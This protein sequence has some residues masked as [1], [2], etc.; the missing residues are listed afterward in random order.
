MASSPSSISNP[1]EPDTA[2]IKAR[3]PRPRRRPPL[4]SFCSINQKHSQRVRSRKAAC[5]R[6]ERR[7]RLRDRLAGPAAELVAHML[8]HEPLSRNDIDGL[9]DILPHLRQLIAAAAWTGGRH[10]VNDARARQVIRKVA[11]RRLAALK[12]LNGD[13]WRFR[14]GSVLASICSQLLELQF[15]LIDEPLAAPLRAETTST[16]LI[17][18]SFRTRA[19]RMACTSARTRPVISA[20]ARRPPIGQLRNVSSGTVVSDSDPP[21]RDSFPN[22]ELLL[23]KNCVL[24]DRSPSAKTRSRRASDKTNSAG[25]LKGRLPRPPTTNGRHFPA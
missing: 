24:R 5:D 8:G 19:N 20:R 1:S 14:L 17:A 21:I 13:D 23:Q 25:V 18:P 16:R 3:A 15:Q 9:G 6:M 7:G 10:R 12:T 2:R 22:H 4:L 11:P